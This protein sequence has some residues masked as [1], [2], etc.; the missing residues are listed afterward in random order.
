VHMR[1][2]D[3]YLNRGKLCRA[4]IG[5]DGVVSTIVNWVTHKGSGD[6][7][8]EVG[9]LISPRK[10]FVNWVHQKPLRVGDRVQVRIL[11]TESVDKPTKRR[12]SDPAEEL[13]RKKRYVRM[14]AKEFGWKI[15]SQPK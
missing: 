14:M 9:G 5:N 2:F 6:L 8:L 12:S 4:G 7:F 3:V 10:E 11:E 1:A 15:Q 13:K